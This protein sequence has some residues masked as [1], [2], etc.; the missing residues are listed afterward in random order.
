[1]IASENANNLCKIIPVS[2]RV[3]AKWLRGPLS[4]TL[5][6]GSSRGATQANSPRTET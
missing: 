6:T 5:E 1:V 3:T 2:P 4:A